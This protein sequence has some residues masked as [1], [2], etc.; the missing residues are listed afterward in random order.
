M[1]VAPEFNWPQHWVDG[2]PLVDA[3][4]LASVQLKLDSAPPRKGEVCRLRNLDP[5]VHL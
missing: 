1:Q 4:F 5:L 3:V 2:V